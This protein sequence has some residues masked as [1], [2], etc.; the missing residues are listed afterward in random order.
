MEAQVD[1]IWDGE[2]EASMA[3]A[4]SWDLDCESTV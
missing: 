1:D 2:E 3:E 4:S